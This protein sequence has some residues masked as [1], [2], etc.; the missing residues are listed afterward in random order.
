MPHESPA[1]PETHST[2]LIQDETGNRIAT[3]HVTDDTTKQQVCRLVLMRCYHELSQL[4]ACRLL[5]DCIYG[6]KGTF[7]DSVYIAIMSANTLQGRPPR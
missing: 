6:T 7:R 2:V 3:G 5:A 4:T 1:D